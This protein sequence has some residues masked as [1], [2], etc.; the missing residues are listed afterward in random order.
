MLLKNTEVFGCAI[1]IIECAIIEMMNNY[2]F[3]SESEFSGTFFLLRHDC[4]WGENM[5]YERRPISLLLF[6]IE[7]SKENGCQDN[8][9]KPELTFTVRTMNKS[10]KT[11]DMVTMNAG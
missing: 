9:Y 4:P 11:N 7:K 3:L 1:Q 5:M 2:F 10:F 8:S 6:N